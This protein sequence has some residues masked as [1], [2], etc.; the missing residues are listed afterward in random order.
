MSELISEA[1]TSPAPPLLAMLLL[2]PAMTSVHQ[3]QAAMHGH[4]STLKWGVKPQISA[5][6]NLQ[7]APR[8]HQIVG[9]GVLFLVLPLL[10]L[11]PLPLPA[12]APMTLLPTCVSMATFAPSRPPTGVMVLVILL[13]VTLAATMCCRQLALVN[14]ISLEIGK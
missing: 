13:P 11:L 3:Q 9:S 4:S 6:S 1:M 2:M 5:G 14:V 12:V 8:A 7:Q 10:P